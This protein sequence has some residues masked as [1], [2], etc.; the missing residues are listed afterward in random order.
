MRHCTASTV[1]PTY[2]QHLVVVFVVRKRAG[3]IEVKLYLHVP[4]DNF[5]TAMCLLYMTRSIRMSYTPVSYMVGTGGKAL[6]IFLTIVI[7]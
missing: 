1:V 2:G 6:E 7:I 4:A 5:C 3:L